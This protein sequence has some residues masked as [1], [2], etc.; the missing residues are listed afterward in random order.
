MLY[1]DRDQKVWRAR[2]RKGGRES[3]REGGMKNRGRRLVYMY[4]CVEAFEW[5]CLLVCQ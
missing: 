4:V 5:V 2:W 3:G 1:S